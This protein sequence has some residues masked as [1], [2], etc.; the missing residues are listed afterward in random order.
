MQPIRIGTRHNAETSLYLDRS[1]LKAHVHSI[2]ASRKGK[3]KLIEWVAR[4][5]TKNR[6]GF[7][8]ID[9][10]G[11][12]YHDLLQ[13]LAYIKPQRNKI[14][15]FNPSNDKRVVG[16]NP[17]RLGEEKTEATITAK[18]DRLV[19]ATMKA[20]GSADISAMPR[21]ERVMRC[22]YYVLIE[23]DLSIDSLR[24]FL[25][26]RHFHLRDIIVS[27]CKSEAMQDS[28][29]MLIGEKSD[30]AY[31]SQMESAANRLFRI[32]TNQTFRRV[33]G[34]QT[35]NISIREIVNGNGILLA[36]MQSTFTFS[37]ESAKVLGTLLVNEIWETIR[38]RTREEA[39]TLPKFFLI[40][41]EFQTFITPDIVPMLDQSAKY[42]LSLMLFH[43][44][45][46]QLDS[47]LLSATTACHTK[48]VFGGV[49]E[50]DARTML[51]GSSPR[52]LDIREDTRLVPQLAP[53]QFMLRR[54]EKRLEY[55]TAPFVHDYP[56]P[57]EKITE[58]VDLLTSNFL[59]SEA[60]DSALAKTLIVEETITKALPAAK[61]KP[62]KQAEI[63]S[64]LP[65]A[66]PND[67][68]T[69]T[70]PNDDDFYY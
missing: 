27:R 46:S 23:Q 60:V 22:L 13:W 4:E 43:Q 55:A 53:A 70:A 37:A 36:N 57:E 44:N 52:T 59:T 49:S 33:C 14:F 18:V 56:L 24:Y 66:L 28:F 64:T 39:K 40:M 38:Q 2:G 12:L 29:A 58:Y 3:S 50:K 67:A 17:F 26:P 31:L 62:I 68:G 32:I 48:F 61:A 34:L 1:D 9:P 8:V 35:N 51:E 65:E 45:L 20:L 5:F 30:N 10:N 41:D 7:C 19:G 16:F 6:Q 25:S 42:G 15:L 11:F 21:L 63:P 47:Q 54:P 69:L